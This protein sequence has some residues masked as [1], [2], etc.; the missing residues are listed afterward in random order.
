M[1]YRAEQPATGRCAGNRPAA[2]V[3]PVRLYNPAF[4]RRRP[5]RPWPPALQGPTLAVR[6][7]SSWAQPTCPGLIVRWWASW[8]SCRRTPCRHIQRRGVPCRRRDKYCLSMRPKRSTPA[9][10]YTQA[11]VYLSQGWRDLEIRYT[12]ADDRPNLRILWQPPGKLACASRY[13]RPA[14]RRAIPGRRPLAARTRPARPA[15]SAMT[16]S[17]SYVSE[18]VQPQTVMPPRTC[19]PCCLEEAPAVDGGCGAGVRAS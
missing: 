2:M 10:A 9:P 4:A 12:P 16:L 6:M 7:T 11:G 3:D 17:P 19:R 1:R 18:L 5:D 15:S 14:P 8:R 13:L